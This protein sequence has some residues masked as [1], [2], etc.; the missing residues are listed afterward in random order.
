MFPF[1][2]GGSG[3]QTPFG[4]IKAG[5]V[6]VNGIE[7]LKALGKK[8]SRQ[9]VFF[10]KRYGSCNI[11]TFQSY[12]GCSTNEYSGAAEALKWCRRGRLV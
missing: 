7:G 1:V 6:E 9:T 3:P 4:G 10:N 12:R 8:K 2:H 11:N 5:V